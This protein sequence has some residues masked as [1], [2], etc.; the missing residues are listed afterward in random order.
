MNT[1]KITHHVP[2]DE[3]D[4]SKSTVTPCVD[5]HEAWGHV[6]KEETYDIEIYAEYQGEEVEVVDYESAQEIVL[7]MHIKKALEDE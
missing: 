3:I 6:W 5:Q 7:E 4:F 2:L 1:L